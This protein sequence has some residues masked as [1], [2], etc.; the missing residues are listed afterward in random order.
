[1][2]P[3]RNA[4][5]RG[6]YAEA[7]TL[8]EA[9]IALADKLLALR[10]GHRQALASKATAFTQLAS[11]EE[12]KLNVADG[13]RYHRE[14]LK[15]QLEATALDAGSSRSQNNLRR[16]YGQICNGLWSQGQ[17]DAALP[18]CDKSLELGKD[19]RIDGF[20]ALNMAF[21]HA[22]YATY[23]TD[24]GNTQRGAREM[25][26]AERYIGVMKSSGASARALANARAWIGKARLEVALMTGGAAEWAKARSDMEQ[27]IADYIASLGGAAPSAGAAFALADAHGRAAEIALALKDFAGAEAHARNAL[28]YVA[29]VESLSLQ[30]QLTVNDIRAI[31]ATALARQ[32]KFDE[33]KQGLQPALAYFKLPLVM[34]TD[35]ETMKYWNARVLLAAAIANGDKPAEKTKFLA[36]ATKRFD[37]MPATLKRLKS[38]TMLREQI[39]AEGRR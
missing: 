18:L 30:Q 27:A 26:E 1:M 5:A 32:G 7:R 36:E 31:L 8:L 16:S 11:I 22:L 13:L 38:Y 19:E 20:S 15:V 14:A 2:E 29:S 25:A 9:C 3:S 21:G 23:Q 12:G 10:P 17:L 24:I 28:A 37:A 6:K 39:A 4:D 35:D 34:Q 33:A